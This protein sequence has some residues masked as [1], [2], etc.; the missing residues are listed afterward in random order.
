MTIWQLLGIIALMGAL[1]GV[2]NALISDNGFALPRRE[3]AAGASI[4]RPG[5][6]GNILLGVVAAILFWGLYG[7]FAEVNVVGEDPRTD[8]QVAGPTRA[9][10]DDQFGE[11]LSGLVAAI[12]VGAGGARVITAEVDKRLLRAA[13]THAANG[14]ASPEAATTIAT[15]SPA[16]ALRRAASM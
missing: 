10:E 14:N 16:D 4:L 13:A 3:T 5:F 6:L 12:V 9:E 11:T 1:G 2:A 7:P 8:P 15:A